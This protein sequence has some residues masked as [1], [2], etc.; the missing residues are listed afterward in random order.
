MLIFL[1]KN[2]S[3]T[4]QEHKMHRCYLKRIISN[5]F[6]LVLNSQFLYFQQTYFSVSNSAG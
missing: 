2:V 4:S 6:K 3:L 1:K 5:D